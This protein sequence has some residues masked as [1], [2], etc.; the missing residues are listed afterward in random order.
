MPLFRACDSPAWKTVGEVIAFIAQVFEASGTQFMHEHHFAHRDCQIMNILYD[1]RP[2]YPNMFHPLKYYF[3]DFGLSRRY[4]PMDGPPREHPIR[5]G[6]KSVP[7][8]QPGVWKGELLDPFPTDIYYL[9]NLIRMDIM[10]AYR[11]I[12]FLVPLVKDMVQDDSAKRPTIQDVVRHFDEL[13]RPLKSR[14]LRS[15]LVPRKED[16]EDAFLRRI[17]HA[18][19]TAHCLLTRKHAM[20][21]PL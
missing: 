4:D 5:G 6:D 10:K 13:V 7:E 17:T 3:I 16:A 2:L 19:R 21:K 9:G 15:R 8:F 18:F 14:Q 1:P 12:E 11:G 20:P